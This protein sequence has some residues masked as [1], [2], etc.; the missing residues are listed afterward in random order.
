M[1]KEEIKDIKSGK[2]DLRKFG[3][4][5]GVVFLL[6]SIP[7]Y[8]TGKALFIF[9]G[10]IGVLLMSFGFILPNVLKP[11]NK[12]WMTLAIILGWFMSRVILVILF[13]IIITPMALLLKIIGKDFLKLRSNEGTRTYWE[14][15]DKKGTERLDYERQF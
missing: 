7:L 10:G 12:I 9:F 8:L 15:R 14:N 2:K 6:I 13:Y 4:T 3:I 11:A 1:F 5:I